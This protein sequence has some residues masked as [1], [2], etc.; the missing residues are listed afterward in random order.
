MAAK[1]SSAR[2]GP[3]K[4][5]DVSGFYKKGANERWQI[6]RE[7]GELEASEI[8]TIRNTGALRF[9]AA[10]GGKPTHFAALAYGGGQIYTTTANGVSAFQLVGP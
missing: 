5:S 1:P 6:I 3:L 8:D 7:F 2:G 9:Q 10:L 4:R